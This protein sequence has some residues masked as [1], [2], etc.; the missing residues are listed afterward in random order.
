M[1]FEYVNRYTK[2]VLYNYRYK[3]YYSKIRIDKYMF[4]GIVGSEL[5]YCKI[6]NTISFFIIK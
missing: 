3:W 4:F 6:H 5:N 2:R 1:E